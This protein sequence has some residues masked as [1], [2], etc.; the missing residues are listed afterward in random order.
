MRDA[1][2]ILGWLASGSGTSDMPLLLAAAHPDDETIGFGGQLPRFRDA[3]I[4]HVTDG[5]PRDGADAARHGFTRPADY[6]AARRAELLAALALAGIG[7]DRAL[8]LG[9]PDQQAS[10]HLEPLA[11]TI[12]RLILE[13][14]PALVVTHAY[15]GG[16][17]D[18][19][20]TAFAVQAA[21]RLLPGDVTRPVLLEMACYHAAPGGGMATGCFLPAAGPTAG[22]EPVTLALSPEACERKRRM[23]ACFPTQREMLA[24]F[25]I[26]AECLRPAPCHDFTRPPHPGRLHYE[27]FSWGMTGER[28][29]ALAAAALRGLGLGGAPCA[30]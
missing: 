25:P 9:L 17:P 14:R 7:V 20:A 30:A 4:L 23:V 22:A 8:T 1:A 15:E 6:A 3:T 5:A 18:H 28:F 27:N 13:R 12:A 11:R 2:A 10:L 19:D 29:R 21:L 24:L 26:G 16:H